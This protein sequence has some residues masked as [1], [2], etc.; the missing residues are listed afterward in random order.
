MKGYCGRIAKIGEAD[1]KFCDRAYALYVSEGR[2]KTLQISVLSRS[3][4]QKANK[5]YQSET[6]QK[7]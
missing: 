3:E 2:F 4:K 6:T 5:A 1:L 7:K